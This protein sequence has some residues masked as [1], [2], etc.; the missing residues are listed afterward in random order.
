MTWE[1]EEMIVQLKDAFA[2]T[3][4]NPHYLWY[5]I[6]NVNVLRDHFPKIY[7]RLQN[8]K[9]L[10]VG[11]ASG[12]KKL[13]VILRTT[14][15]VMNLNAS[16][17]LE[18]FGIK[19]KSEVIRAGG[20]SLFPAAE[21]FAAAYGRENIS[22]TLVTDRLSNA[23]MSLYRSAADA[24]GLAS[25][26]VESKGHGNGLTFQTQIDVALCDDDDTLVFILEDDYLLDEAT[27]TTC[28]KVMQEHA[29][30]IGIN[31][32][33]HPDRVRRQD[34]GRL[35]AVGG[36]LYCQIKSTCCTFF[37][38]VR[39]MKHFEKYLRLYDGWEKGSVSVAWERGL[40]LAPIGWT[41]AEHLHRSDLSPFVNFQQ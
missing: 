38:P 29:N 8:C 31:P 16:R 6:R 21:K 25:N 22:I 4:S 10:D 28:F 26:V 5:F 39:A 35:V 7:R 41:M 17:Q 40:C 1:F 19:T 15:F 34:A 9:A 2:K 14:D 3:W 37:M 32:H 18:D 36:K 13:H 11:G 12:L 24:E 27:L 23:G 20:C 30:V 33:F